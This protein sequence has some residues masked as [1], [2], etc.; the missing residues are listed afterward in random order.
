LSF[1]LPGAGQVRLAV[2]D[3]AG[4]LVRVLVDGQ[5]PAGPCSVA[6]DGRDRAGREVG[7]GG[8]LARLEF[9]GAHAVVKLQV[10]R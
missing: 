3:A 9:G 10:V 1:D 5:L 8:Y 7:S 4:R 6:W 2:F